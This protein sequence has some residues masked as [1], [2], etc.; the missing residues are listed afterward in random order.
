MEQG[1]WITVYKFYDVLEAQELDALFK[2]SSIPAR[3]ISRQDSAFGVLLKAWIGLGV[4][5]VKENDVNESK[6]IISEFEK[7]RKQDMDRF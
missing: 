7:D 2:Q 5:Q 6:K 1:K 3:I 4:F